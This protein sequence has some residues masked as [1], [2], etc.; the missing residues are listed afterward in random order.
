M[1][2]EIHA[3]NKNEIQDIDYETYF[4]EMDLSDEEK[5][6]R[7][8]LAEKF[9]KIFVMLFALLSGKEE[10]EITTITKEF[11]IRYESI[12]QCT[13]LRKIRE[14]KRLKRKPVK[15]NKLA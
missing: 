3:L 12:C 13:E 2:D 9:E 10:T 14:K 5:E 1:A 4:G 11:I 6:D 8:K 7:K 15:K